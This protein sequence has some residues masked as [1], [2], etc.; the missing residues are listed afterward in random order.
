MD[1]QTNTPMAPQIP[2]DDVL[3]KR[4]TEYRNIICSRSG[5]HTNVDSIGIWNELVQLEI[6]KITDYPK[7][8]STT[9]M[10]E[11][12]TPQLVRDAFKQV[13]LRLSH[14]N[15]LSQ[16]CSYENMIG[17]IDEI[18]S[19]VIGVS[20]EGY[21]ILCSTVTW[22]VVFGLL[23]IWYKCRHVLSIAEV[24]HIYNECPFQ[25][26]RCGVKHSGSTSHD[27]TTAGGLLKFFYAKLFNAL[28]Y[29]ELGRH[30]WSLWYE[31]DPDLHTDG[32]GN[33]VVWLPREM[34][35]DVLNLLPNFLKEKEGEISTTTL[36]H[37]DT[38]II[39]DYFTGWSQ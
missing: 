30:V 29:I 4:L 18:L 3:R 26:E 19:G 15:I 27:R 2:N 12:I 22:T 9:G 20:P 11:E 28:P 38:K 37:A 5:N 36:A 32:V 10:Q 25:V 17:V 14:H 24:I 33:F 7:N 35:E 31:N 39:L 16:E 34:V 23:Q 21:S 8:L 6:G 1:N 13:C